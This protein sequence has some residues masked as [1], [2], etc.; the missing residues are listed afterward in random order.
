MIGAS[1]YNIFRAV[2]EWLYCV[3]S[4]DGWAMVYEYDHMSC[5]V[6]VTRSLMRIP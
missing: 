1:T 6:N 3:E 2:G 4:R 5:N